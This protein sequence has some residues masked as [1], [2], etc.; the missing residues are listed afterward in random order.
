MNVIAY[1]PFQDAGSA[2]AVG[3]SDR[4]IAAAADSGIRPRCVTCAAVLIS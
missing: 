1:S 3:E 4:A 2:D